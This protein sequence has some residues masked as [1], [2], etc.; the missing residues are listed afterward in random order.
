MS[1]NYESNHSNMMAAGISRGA[2]D[3]AAESLKEPR[4]IQYPPDITVLP[5]PVEQGQQIV[6]SDINID[7]VFTAVW[8]DERLVWQR[9]VEK[10]P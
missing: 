6:I 10:R 9:T 2:F 5:P 1:D 8:Q 4:P 3:A 7:I